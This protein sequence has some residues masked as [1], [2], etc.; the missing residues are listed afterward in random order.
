MMQTE[1]DL[2]GVDRGP[3]DQMVEDL[4][5]DRPNF[6]ATLGYNLL[7]AGLFNFGIIQA[8]RSSDRRKQRLISSPAFSKTDFRHA[9]SVL[10]TTVPLQKSRQDR[11]LDHP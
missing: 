3:V 4:E 2:N 8:W 7:G 5:K 1:D 6:P 9:L 11:T 10:A